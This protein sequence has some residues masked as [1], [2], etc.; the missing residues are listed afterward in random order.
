MLLLV[1]LG[2]CA[3]QRTTQTLSVEQNLQFLVDAEQPDVLTDVR[4]TISN[5][6]RGPSE[7]EVTYLKGEK[8]YTKS[9]ANGVLGEAEEQEGTHYAGP[10]LDPSDFPLNGIEQLNREKKCSNGTM[11]ARIRM[12]P[13]DRVYFAAKCGGSR[14][15]ERIGEHELGRIPIADL[16]TSHGLDTII[17]EFEL[18]FGDQANAR[19][20]TVKFLSDREYPR[21]EVDYVSVQGCDA[22]GVRYLEPDEELDVRQRAD[23]FSA[24][25]QCFADGDGEWTHP[26]SQFRLRDID[27]KR[28]VAALEW[29]RALPDVTEVRI[30]KNATGDRLTLDAQLGG[31][32]GRKR[33]N[34][35]SGPSE[36]TLSAGTPVESSGVPDASVAGWSTTKCA[37][38]SPDCY[39]HAHVEQTR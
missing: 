32:T 12:L 24:S 20:I 15:T 2:G 25:S 6:P 13:T 11:H 4:V 23:L 37:P 9:V 31:P 29:T 27:R 35:T 22:R 17:D 10:I 1:S 38:F 28:L 21:I 34:S 7:L 8:E 3:P 19:T 36:S 39:R 18:A 5:N 30:E 26:E 33:V 14:I 16:Y